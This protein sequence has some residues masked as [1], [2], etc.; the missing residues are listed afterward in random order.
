MGAFDYLHSI[1]YGCIAFDI[2]T[3]WSKGRNFA[4][5]IIGHILLK[6]N[7]WICDHWNVLLRMQLRCMHQGPATRP[8][9]GDCLNQLQDLVQQLI[10]QSALE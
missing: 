5:D 7:V 6:E 10:N 4:Y 9:T 2:I 8:V 1:A 3:L